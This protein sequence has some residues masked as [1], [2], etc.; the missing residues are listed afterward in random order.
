MKRYKLRL[1]SPL[2]LIVVLLTLPALAAYKAHHNDKDTVWFLQAYPEAKDQKV[3]NCYLCHT[4]GKVEK[5]YLDA[6]DYCHAVYGYKAPHPAASLQKTLNP[7]GVAYNQ[8]GRNIEA[9]AVIADADSDQDGFSNHT[10]IAAGHLPGEANDNP[11]AQEAPYLVYS[12]EKLKRLPQVSQFMPIDTAKAG[13]YYATYAGIS[14]MDLLADA[15]IIN[16]A[17]DITVFSADGYS[18]NYALDE[19]IQTYQPGNYFSY[20]P[21]ISHPN[22]VAYKNGQVISG[23]LHYLVAFERDGFPLTEG[24]IVAGGDGGKFSLHGEGPFR[25]IAPSFAPIV[26]DRSQ[27]SIDRGDPLYPY[28]PNRPVLKNADYCIKTIVAIQVNTDSTKFFQN[29]WN[30]KAWQMVQKGQLVIYGAIQP[31]N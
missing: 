21:W 30:T 24:G 29:N 17:T 27:W 18:R 11:A 9:F 13:D 22:K 25:F 31:A 15:G 5:K 2:L 3:D 12:I 8:A 14:V 4:G 10:E 26:P 23:R 1:I 19:L 6:C 28:N 7:F 20:Y 16:S